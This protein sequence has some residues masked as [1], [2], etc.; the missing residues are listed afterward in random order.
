[1]S[2]AISSPSHYKQFTVEVIQFTSLVP[3][4]LGNSLKYVC[5][6]GHKAGEPFEKDL[7]KA[8][9]YAE[10][11]LRRHRAFSGYPMPYLH[12]PEAALKN[13]LVDLAYVCPPKVLTGMPDE[14]AR[15]T[16]V[17][18]EGHRNEHRYGMLESL[19]DVLVSLRMDGS[20]AI[21]SMFV[22]QFLSKLAV[23]KGLVDEDQPNQDT[24]AY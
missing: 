24:S 5:R 1:M 9:V 19:L 8:A 6:A 2:D 17:S 23:A 14:K 11:F 12:G 16:R 10:D 15:K 4:D 22:A 21:R 18:L 13:Y 7:A 3:G 20:V